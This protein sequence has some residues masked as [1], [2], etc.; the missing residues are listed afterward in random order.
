MRVTCG[1]SIQKGLWEYGQKKQS[2]TS[3]CDTPKTSSE[4]VLKSPTMLILKVEGVA[5]DAPPSVENEVCFAGRQYRLLSCMLYGGNYTTIC[6]SGSQWFKITDSSVSTDTKLRQQ[7][8]EHFTDYLMWNQ[9]LIF[10]HLQTHFHYHCL[11]PESFHGI[12]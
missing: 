8:N 9:I 6:R 7:C 1:T 11:Q 10:H 5:G 2:L 3:C 4:V 12:L